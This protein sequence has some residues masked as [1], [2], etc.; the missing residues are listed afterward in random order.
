MAYISSPLKHS[1]S[2]LQRL[3]SGH[4]Q[5]CSCLFVSFFPLK[6]LNSGFFCSPIVFVKTKNPAE[7][8]RTYIQANVLK[9]GSNLRFGLFALAVIADWEK[10]LDNHQHVYS[11]K[12]NVLGNWSG[13]KRPFKANTLRWNLINWEPNFKKKSKQLLRCQ[14]ELFIVLKTQIVSSRL[15]KVHNFC[16]QLYVLFLLLLSLFVGRVIH[17]LLP[18]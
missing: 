7:L 4:G 2:A 18:A 9:M 10:K 6:N 1:L 13:K 14:N 11:K 8:I 12:N 3:Q 17:H 15:I 5:P 16:K